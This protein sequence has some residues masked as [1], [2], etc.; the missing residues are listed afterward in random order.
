[1][2]YLISIL[3]TFISLSL[4]AQQYGFEQF[5]DSIE[6][7]KHIT[8]LAGDS[9]EGRETGTKGQ[10]L[11]ADYIREVFKTYSLIPSCKDGYFQKFSFFES[12]PK[13]VELVINDKTV[14]NFHGIIY[15]GKLCNENSKKEILFIGE[16]SDNDLMGLN[17]EDK[18]LLLFSRKNL[19]KILSS[20]ESLKYHSILYVPVFS[21]E[22]FKQELKFSRIPFSLSKKRPVGFDGV[23]LSGFQQNMNSE[24][25]IIFNISPK[26][27]EE[28]LNLPIDSIKQIIVSN[29]ADR[30]VNQLKSLKCDSI[31]YDI[32]IPV[33][34]HETENVVGML[35]S[36]S[37]SD[38][39]LIV[40]AHYDHL[41]RKADKIF[42]GA[43]D[44]ASGV[45]AML[46]IIQA[47][48]MAK[49]SE[50]SIPVNIVFIAAT[51]EEMGLWGSRYYSLNPIYPLNKTIGD[52][53]LD[54]LGRIDDDNTDSENYMYI[55]Q[56]SN[57]I[58][59]LA[60]YFK[61]KPDFRI[62]VRNQSLTNFE[63]RASDQYS[64]LLQHIPGVLITSGS[65]A[66]YHKVTDTAD[67]I[68]YP[69]LEKRT[70][71]ILE[72]IVEI[73]KNQ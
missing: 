16:G 67:K 61:S 22:E 12:S 62:I 36:D 45:S 39:Y 33:V 63:I 42:H 68:D 30:A 65:H 59:Q 49:S 20:K 7:R 32:E 24:S 9:L 34:Y 19:S 31:R 15:E 8:V 43:D 44:N 2:K 52:I 73:F 38:K 46:E 13:R 69:L 37:G 56:D 71:L 26:Y 55:F 6:L 17:T 29:K 10:K 41:G 47:L 21:E 1:M 57:T 51:G 54:M 72:G 11:A 18:A 66:D 70:K 25:D 50:Y 60:Q 64:F 48:S 3:L 27:A 35:R 28:I 14:T 53:N 58:N 23:S 5:V 40:S 4:S